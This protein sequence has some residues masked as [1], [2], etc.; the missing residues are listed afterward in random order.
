MSRPP[1]QSSLVPVF[2]G[3]AILLMI[4]AVGCQLVFGDYQINTDDATGGG[5]STVKS[6]TVPSE[7]SEGQARCSESGD[8]QK[9]QAG[10][11]GAAVACGDLDHCSEVAGVCVEC[12]PGQTRCTADNR[13]VQ[14]CNLQRTGWEDLETCA[15]RCFAD[16]EGALCVQ[17]EPFDT[18]TC[19]EGGDQGDKLRFCNN[20]GQLILST[21]SGPDKQC[22][23][24]ANGDDFCSECTTDGFRCTSSGILKSCQNH[25]E[26][27][28]KSC[29]T[30]EKCDPIG[31]GCL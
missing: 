14:L 8:L 11:W 19:E 28:I 30:F 1:F 22:I 17:C 25:R 12:G 31:P 4:S 15:T 18:V 21:C 6:T 9:C 29:G 2:R 23:T 16:A 24:V 7:C 5:G 26:T 20:K 27:E 10:K 3:A 13:K